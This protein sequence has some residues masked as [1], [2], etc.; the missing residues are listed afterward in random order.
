[1]TRLCPSSFDE[2]LI[3]G[4]L[5]DELTQGDDQRVRIH[6]EDCEQ[7]RRIHQGLKEMREATMT[8]QF[9]K[10]P[11]RQWNERPHGAASRT[12]FALGWIVAIVWMVTTC[13]YAGWQ[14]WIDTGG[15][16]EKTLIFG[17]LAAIALLFSS[18]VI[19]RLHTARTDPYRKVEK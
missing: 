13:G 7:C 11:D 16:F 4:Y 9:I 8:T 12:G 6:M 10:E 2:T 18:V 14:I 3:T 17:G 5:D 15:W 19:D 1:M